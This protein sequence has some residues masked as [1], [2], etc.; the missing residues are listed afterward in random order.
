VFNDVY[1]KVRCFT[2]DWSA[3]ESRSAF[4]AL[5]ATMDPG[6]LEQAKTVIQVNAMWRG[7]HGCSRFILQRCLV[8]VFVFVFQTRRGAAAA[9]T[10][11]GADM[12]RGYGTGGL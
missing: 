12:L 9:D 10:T 4:R 6:D 3:L 2:V 7:A 1:M 5:I 8:F 11:R